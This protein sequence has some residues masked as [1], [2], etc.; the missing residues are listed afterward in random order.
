MLRK[1][2]PWIGV[3]VAVLVVFAAVPA[4]AGPNKASITA[5]GLNPH[6]DYGQ[7]VTFTTVTADRIEYP[8]VNARC[9]QDGERVYTQWHG[10]FDSYRYDP[11]FSLG[12]T[13]SWQEGDAECIAE[14]GVRKNG[15]FRV[16]ASYEFVVLDKR[17]AVDPSVAST[18]EGSVP[19]TDA[20][21]TEEPETVTEDGGTVDVVPSSFVGFL[22][23]A[24]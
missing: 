22:N 2:I 4:F 23:V 10:A 24:I 6:G 21:R 16:L 19:Q 17:D 3:I 1:R 5:D 7:Q 14:V 11:V 13:Q 9:Y 18:D 12:P 20:P 8:W 15:R